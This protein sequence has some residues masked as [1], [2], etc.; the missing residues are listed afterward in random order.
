MGHDKTN[1]K[2]QQKFKKCTNNCFQQK[3]E[4]EKAKSKVE[5]LRQWL[6]KQERILSLSFSLINNLLATPF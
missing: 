1:K 6:Q 5:K 3:S 4:D 2:I